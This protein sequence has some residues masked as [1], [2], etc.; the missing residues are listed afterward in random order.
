MLS[1]IRSIVHDGWWAL[2]LVIGAQSLL[3]VIRIARDLGPGGR[4]SADLLVLSEV[5]NLLVT[6]AS[7]TLSWLFTWATLAILVELYA[8]LTERTPADEWDEEEEVEE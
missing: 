7:M 3:S 8:V 1:R 4:S 6:T 5:F 2:W